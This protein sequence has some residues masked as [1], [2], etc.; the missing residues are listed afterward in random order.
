MHLF[1]N[2]FGVY[3][4]NADCERASFTLIGLF[5]LEKVTTDTSR[6]INPPIKNPTAE[7]GDGCVAVISKNNPTKSLKV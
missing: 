2:V 6:S 5:P 1:K 3:V 7:L 4:L